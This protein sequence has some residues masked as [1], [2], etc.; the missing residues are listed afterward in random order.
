M[1]KIRDF[2]ELLAWS[3]VACLLALN[4]GAIVLFTLGLVYGTPAAAPASV[5]QNLIYASP[6]FPLILGVV[7]VARLKLGG[8]D[9]WSTVGFSRKTLP[10]D[11]LMGGVAGIAS[12]GLAVA[13]LR[14][15]AHFANVPPM[16]LLPTPVHLYFMTIGALI[17][18]VCEELFFRGM[19]MRVARHLPAVAIVVLTAAAFSLWHV[20]TPAY[21]PHTALLGLI[22][23]V[24]A[25][26]SGRLAPSII[27][28]TIANAGMGL[29]LLCGFN[30]AGQ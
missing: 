22:F 30:I 13:S 24:L 16:H 20:E 5:L 15:V 21:L 12:I 9:V 23:G 6:A 19:M 25:N 2:A 3:A 14:I 17:P 7:A 28:H 1:V 10:T 26:A 18:G 27:A 4:S 29:L 11:A 8:Y